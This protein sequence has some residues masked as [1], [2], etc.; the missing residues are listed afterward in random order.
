[1]AKTVAMAPPLLANNHPIVFRAL[2][3]CKASCRSTHSE[4]IESFDGSC[5]SEIANGAVIALNLHQMPAVAEQLRRA[6]EEQ[7]LDVYQVAEITKIKTD[8][9]RALESGNYNVFA[10]PVYIRGFI[11]TYAKVL[12]L[13][14]TQL[15]ADLEAELGRTEK[16][17]ELP[18]LT[19]KPRGA[20]DFLMLMMSRLNWRVATIVAGAAIAVLLVWIGFRALKS[21]NETDPLKNLGPG[22][23]ESRPEQSGELLPLPTNTAPKI[24]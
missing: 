5:V 12:K 15:I 19:K 18:P 13:D 2:I 20:L 14:E 23:Y 17:R 7:K 4:S 10:A 6:R 9:I 22:L 24:R 8:H 1:M 21:R 16:F 3:L 11:R